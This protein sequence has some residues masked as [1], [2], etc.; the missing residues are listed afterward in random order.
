MTPHP[1]AKLA[2]QFWAE[3]EHDCTAYRNWQARSNDAETWSDCDGPPS[4]A[5]YNQYRRKPSVII[6]NGIEVPEPCR[7]PLEKGQDYFRPSLSVDPWA[8]KNMWCNDEFDKA[9]LDAGCVHL[10][11]EAAILHAQALLSFT[12][13]PSQTS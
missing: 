9:W 3:M 5:K 8:K 6:I 11:K 1:H 12:C 4:F 7:E 13:K 2:Q 10:T